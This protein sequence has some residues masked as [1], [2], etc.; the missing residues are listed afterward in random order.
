MDDEP[1]I[2][3]YDGFKIIGDVG[4]N[5]ITCPSSL[6]EICKQFFS[7]LGRSLYTY[8]SSFTYPLNYLCT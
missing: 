6:L 2:R 1:L 8:F 3:P 7:S 5:L 4:K